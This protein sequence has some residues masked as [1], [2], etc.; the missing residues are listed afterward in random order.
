[1]TLKGEFG[2]IKANM[3]KIIFA[4]LLAVAVVAVGCV[5]TVSG[6]HSFATSVYPDSVAGRY[7]RSLDQVYNASITVITRNGVLVTEY[8]PH[9]TTN[10]VRSLEGKVQDRTVWISVEAVAPRETEVSVQ[11]RSKWGT[12]DLELVHELEKE[13]ALELDR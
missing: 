1:L 12:T 3:K 6:T 9:D 5:S 13:I 4:G 8:I 2:C 11:A 7:P 10:S